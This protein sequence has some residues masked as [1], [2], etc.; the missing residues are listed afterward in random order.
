VWLLPRGS[1]IAPS[2]RSR[3]AGGSEGSSSPH[4]IDGLQ[5]A[6]AP[7]QRMAAL[8]LGV[9]APVCDCGAEGTSRL[10]GWCS[11]RQS[12]RQRFGG[13]DRTSASTSCV[14]SLRAAA[15]GSWACLE[16][17]LQATFDLVGEDD[18][19]CL[20]RNGAKGTE[21]GS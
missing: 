12:G 1:G 14:A 21:G 3:A 4:S 11:N 9:V 6:A 16:E 5:P 18:P 2:S 15:D 8:E 10:V 7:M 13:S 17:T 19:G 20:S